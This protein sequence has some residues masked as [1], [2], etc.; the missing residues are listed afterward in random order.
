V[1]ESWWIIGA[2]LALFAI[3]FLADKVP[4]FDLIWNAL[5]TFV[6]VPVATLLAYTAAA[7][8]S[9]PNAARGSVGWRTGRASL[10]GQDRGVSSGDILAR[11]AFER[12]PQLGRGCPRYPPDLAC[13]LSSLSCCRH[14]VRSD[15]S[16]CVA[17]DLGLADFEGLFHGAEREVVQRRAFS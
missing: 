10:R 4:A 14:C 9:P 7:Q 8:L 1:L 3:E 11:A 2:A 5:H 6:R 13:D 15:N 12:G 16:H 17:C